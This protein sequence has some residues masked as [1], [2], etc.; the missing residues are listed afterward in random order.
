MNGTA[1]IGKSMYLKIDGSTA[2][3]T[4]NFSLSNSKGEINV[5]S[6][7]SNGNEEY[8]L[9][10]IIGRTLT[11]SQGVV[12]QGTH[13]KGKAFSELLNTFYT[14]DS[15]MNFSILPD[16]STNFSISGWGFL[17]TYDVDFGDSMSEV[18]AS[19]TF[20]VNDAS[21]T[22]SGVGYTAS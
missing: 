9:D 16:L 4:K 21:I 19:G 2:V 10:G 13:T 7:D 14:S 18:I 6:R 22:Y 8:V 3:H 15:S 5:M 11:F 20:R 12:R 17:T 1:L